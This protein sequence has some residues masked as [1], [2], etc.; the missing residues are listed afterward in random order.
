MQS[1]CFFYDVA[2]FSLDP[3][4]SLRVRYLFF[5]LFIHETM[6]LDSKMQRLLEKCK[7]HAKQLLPALLALS[8][9]ISNVSVHFPKRRRNITKPY[10]A[11]PL[12]CGILPRAPGCPSPSF[13]G[14]SRS[15]QLNNNNQII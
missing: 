10:F 13:P 7:N 8:A 4:S 6:K 15:K 14:Q 12:S 1:C 5:F 9:E 11:L 3:I 2:R